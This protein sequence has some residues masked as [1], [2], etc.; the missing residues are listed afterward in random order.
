L[1]A[2][3][4][5][6]KQQI[7][8]LGRKTNNEQPTHYTLGKRQSQMINLKTIQVLL[9]NDSDTQKDEMFLQQFYN[10]RTF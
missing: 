10:I 2:D 7:S 3:R 4:L 9:T 1:V 6:S 5:Y 8:Y